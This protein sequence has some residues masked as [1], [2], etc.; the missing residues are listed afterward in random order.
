MRKTFKS[1]GKQKNIFW[2][3]VKKIKFADFIHMYFLIFFLKNKQPLF[4]KKSIG[5][6]KDIAKDLTVNELEVLLIS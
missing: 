2:I 5:W 1:K 4:K 6:K 3:H